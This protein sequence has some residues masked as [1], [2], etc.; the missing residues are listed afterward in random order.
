[1]LA[2]LN[3]VNHWRNHA[4]EARALAD[5]LTDPEARRVMLGIAEGYDKLVQQA[6]VRIA[7]GT[8]RFGGSLN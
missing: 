8:R 5:V 7:A 1:M 4:E 2:L 3:D 6:E